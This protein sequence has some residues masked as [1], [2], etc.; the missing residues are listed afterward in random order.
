MRELL[1]ELRAMGKTIVISSHLL[2][3]LGQL[4]DRVCVLEAGRMITEG[5]VEDLCRKAGV[6][7]LVEVEAAAADDAL[8]RAVEAL[9]SVESA[10]RRGDRLSLRLRDDE[11]AV[12]ALHQALVDSGARLRAFRPAPADLET[13]FMR[14]TRGR[15]A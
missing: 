2:H 5:R 11:G 7:R 14:L 4:C 8:L 15:S 12:E 6:G 3:E 9:P 10:E 1:L 13:L